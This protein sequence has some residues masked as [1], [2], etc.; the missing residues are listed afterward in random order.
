MKWPLEGQ[1][2]LRSSQTQLQLRLESWWLKSR[3]S[4]SILIYP[5]PQ[6]L[7]YFISTVLSSQ[8]H[9]R[10]EEIVTHRGHPCTRLRFLDFWDNPD[11]IILLRFLWIPRWSFWSRFSWIQSE[12]IPACLLSSQCTLLLLNIEFQLHDTEVS[13]GNVHSITQR[14]TMF[15]LKLNVRKFSSKRVISLFSKDCIQT[16]GFNVIFLWMCVF[17]DIR[18]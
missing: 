12:L 7:V 17:M 8:Q 4:N 11:F 9:S 15:Y 18:S 10:S 6:T 3:V 2:S 5:Q 1:E 16:L 14:I 13:V